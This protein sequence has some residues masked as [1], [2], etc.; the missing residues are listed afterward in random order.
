MLYIYIHICNMHVHVHVHVHVFSKRTLVDSCLVLAR[1]AW[2]GRPTWG[3][4]FWKKKHKTTDKLLNYIY[5]VFILTLLIYF[6]Y[7]F[8]IYI[9]PR[10]FYTSCICC[11]LDS[12]LSFNYIGS[13]SFFVKPFKLVLTFDP[14]RGGIGA[15][16]ATLSLDRLAS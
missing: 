2:E 1:R 10:Y 9:T 4:M 8:F 5:F 15:L 14:D 13:H 12:S 6:K 11:L 3:K 16:S 7:V